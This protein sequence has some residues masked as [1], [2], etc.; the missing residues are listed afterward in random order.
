MTRI[1]RDTGDKFFAGVVDTA[2]QLIPAINIH[3]RISPRIFEKVQSGPMEYLGAWGTLIHEKNLKSKISCQT[4]LD[5]EK[6]TI[7]QKVTHRQQ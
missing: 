5:T 3:W 6:K 4:P 7:C 1:D 2:E